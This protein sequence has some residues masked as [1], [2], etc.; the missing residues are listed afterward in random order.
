MRLALIAATVLCVSSLAAHADT[1]YAYTGQSFNQ[2]E[3][4]YTKSDRVMGTITVDK[5]FG[6]NFYNSFTPTAFTFSDGVQTLNSSNTK[7]SFVIS[8]NSQGSVIGY[9]ISIAAGVFDNIDLRDQ[10]GD[11]GETSAFNS[12][13]AYA[14]G[15]FTAPMITQTPEPSSFAL[16]G[17]GLLGVVGVLRRRF[18]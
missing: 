1:V 6:A 3:G 8:T 7:G 9:T 12:G 18:I 16:L 4:T 13:I 17:T 10:S 5:P 2:V 11:L 14:A 15:S